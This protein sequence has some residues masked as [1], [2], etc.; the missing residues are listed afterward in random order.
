MQ[1]LFRRPSGIYVLRLAVPAPLRY[2]VGKREIVATTG[3]R[4]LTIAK[5]VAGVLPYPAAGLAANVRLAL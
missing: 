5:M 2:I 4:E 3:T 1:N